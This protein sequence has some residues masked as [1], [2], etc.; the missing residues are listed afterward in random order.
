MI[1]NALRE[2]FDRFAAKAFEP[3]VTRELVRSERILWWINQLKD[4]KLKRL[5]RTLAQAFSVELEGPSSNPDSLDKILLDGLKFLEDCLRQAEANVDTAQR[6]IGELNTALATGAAELA[7]LHKT[8]ATLRSEYAH[9]SNALTNTRFK[10]TTLVARL[11]A[12]RDF[13]KGGPPNEYADLLEMV[14]ESTACG[15]PMN[16][17]EEGVTTAY[18]LKMAYLNL[19]AFSHLRL[20]V[21]MAPLDS[22][23][24]P[25][26]IIAAAVLDRVL[27]LQK[28][29]KKAL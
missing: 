26:E 2:I 24:A 15:S 17:P 25:Y 23:D 11:Q 10:Q 14:R 4:P 16:V 1:R 21:G 19:R 22:E 13:F 20:S 28:D 8:L 29:P 18:L 3:L 6:K 9:V 27:S 12:Q 5:R 7:Q